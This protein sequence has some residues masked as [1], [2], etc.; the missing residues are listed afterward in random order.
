MNKKPKHLTALALSA[1][2]TLGTGF[3]AGNVALA[4]GKPTVSAAAAKPLKAAQDAMKAGKYQDM[5][6]RLKE[7][8]ALP[9]KSAYDTHLMNEMFAFAYT[10]T[11]QFGEAAKVLEADLNS[12]FVT[13][14]EAQKRAR[15]L[16]QLQYQ[17]KNYDKVIELGNRAIK[18]GYADDQTYTLVGQAMYLKGDHKGS[19]KF[20]ETY[21]NSQIKAGRKPKEQLLVLVQNSCDKIDDSECLTRVLER[22]VSYYPKAQYWQGLVNAM[23]KTQSGQTDWQ[24]LQV[25]RLASAV[26]VLSRP[27]D[28]TEFAQLAL[29]RG[30]PGEA[31]AVLEKG[32]EKKI[33]TEARD[34][35]RN[36]RLLESAKKQAAAKQAELDKAAAA[37]AAAT[38]GQQDISVGMAYFGYQQY[39]KAA[40]AIQRGLAKPGVANPADARLLLGIAELE[41]GR[42]EE[43][44]KAFKQVKGD[45]ALERLAN[46]WTL[47]TQ[48]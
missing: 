48:A 18:E 24:L 7:V 21:V 25:Y 40:Q 42:K 34:Q 3:T 22:L 19:A 2:F 11:N 46:L 27:N 41:A 29:E 10:K 43:A 6:A 9:D 28:Y 38:D 1:V 13:G 4:Q 31:Q 37:A 35:D 8:Q 12:G 5:I 45:P 32:F 16:L 26:D 20:L 36:K 23:Y 15:Q 39:D 44:R 14:A 17:V 47:H 33:F 30:S